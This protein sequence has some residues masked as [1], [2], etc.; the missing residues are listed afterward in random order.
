[1]IQHE[2]RE[3]QPAVYMEVVQSTPSMSARETVVD[4]FVVGWD[5]EKK[6]VSRIYLNEPSGCVLGANTMLGHNILFDMAEKR[7]GIAKL[8]CKYHAGRVE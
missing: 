3:I 2:H 4:D 5:G 6:L 7:I 8:S 1:M